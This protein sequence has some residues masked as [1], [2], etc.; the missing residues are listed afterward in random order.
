MVNEAGWVLSEGIA[1]RASDIDLAMVHGF[2]FPDFRG[3][4]AFWARRQPRGEIEKA[5]AMVQEATG[6]GFR[7]GDVAAMLDQMHLG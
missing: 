2:G 7:R 3:G 6:F 5:L 4:P 1:Q